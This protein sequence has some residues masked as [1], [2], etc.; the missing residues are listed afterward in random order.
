MLTVRSFGFLVTFL[1]ILVIGNAVLYAAE[2][3]QI[4]SPKTLI[5]AKWGPS[6]NEFGLKE[7]KEMETIGPRTFSLDRSGNIYIFDLVKQNIKKFTNEGIYEG[8]LGSNISG[9]AF[10]INYEN[11]HLFVLDDHLLHEYSPTGDLI[12]NHE[13]SRDIEL[14]EGYGQGVIIDDFG[15][16]F[17][18]KIQKMFKIGVTTRQTGKS[19]TSSLSIL[20]KKQQLAS[21]KNGMVSKTRENRFKAKWKDKHKASLQILTDDEVLLKE[22][23]MSTPDIFGGVLFLRKDNNGSIYIEA[24]RITSDNYVHLE[25][26]KFDSGGSLLSIIELPNDY[27]TTVYKKIDVDSSGNIYQL[28]T[29]PTGVQLDKWEQK[30]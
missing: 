30:Q 6:P 17:V 25:L 24:E 16:L 23:E 27:Y 4:Y 28:L 19:A 21:E 10:A 2:Q 29:T 7:G 15:N 1:G 18:N 11:G 9:S 26:R 8:T 20:D 22:V 12:K 14:I 13:I 5:F 3:Y